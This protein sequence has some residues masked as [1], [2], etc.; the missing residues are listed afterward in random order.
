MVKCGAGAAILLI[1]CG[2]ATVRFGS[3]LQMPATTTRDGTLITLSRYL[4]EPVPDVVLVGSS[5]T[6]RLK[7]EYFATAGLRNL[8][9][10]GGSPV[11]GLEIVANQSQLP[12]FILVEA[13][14]LTRPT[15]AALVERYSRGDT[16][17]LFFRPVRAAVAAYEQ[18]LHASVT[19]EQVVLNLRKLTEQPPSDFDNRVYADRALQQFNA[20][21]PADAARI[22]AKRIEELI[23]MVEHRGARVLLFELPYSEPIEG[24]RYAATTRE[25]V[26]AA[27]PDTKRWL[28]VEVNRSELRWADGVHLDERSAVIVTQ[29]MER[30]LALVR[31]VK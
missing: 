10:A 26:H 25:I 1:A 17:P 27:F 29:A 30:T 7:E 20:E 28:P 18:R 31:T 15:D 23:R 9:L 22:N 14:V 12:K 13:N 19:H 4:R 5:I 3:G 11:T 21:D 24:S 2:F 8:A 6:F 16:E